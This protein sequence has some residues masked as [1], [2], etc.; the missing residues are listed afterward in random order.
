M[1]KTAEPE[2][3]MHVPL[4]LYG[5]LIKGK[6][7]FLLVYTTACAYLA[8]AWGTSTLNFSTMMLTLIGTFFAVAGATLLNMYIDRDI[9]EIM[10]RTKHRALPSRRVN[11]RTVL[12]HGIV[13]TIGG[14]VSLGVLI[15]TVTMLVVFAG[16]F[17]DVVIYSMLLKRRSKWSIIFGG[18]AGGMP[19]LAGRTAAIGE[20]D[21]IGLLMALFILTWIPVH[22]LT[23]A[24]FPENMTGYRRAKVPMWP[25]AS[26][27]AQT[28]KLV[29]VGA[30]LCVLTATLTGYLLAIYWIVLLH[31]V[32][33]GAFL[34]FRSLKVVRNPTF[35]RTY[36]VFKSASMFMAFSF[37]NLFLGVVFAHKLS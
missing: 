17:F 30:I 20:V 13:F 2:F 10:E 6:Q 25:V 27:E 4:A 1:C 22:I 34:I 15:N 36:K 14:I 3:T 7:T 32:F 5:E 11:A 16:F 8:S 26:G 18:V 24:M 12:L 19:A 9:D 23:L 21:A 29:A 28:S 31:M 35:E 33:P 37:L